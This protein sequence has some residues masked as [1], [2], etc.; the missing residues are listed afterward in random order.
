[1]DEFAAERVLLAADL[2]PRGRVASY[3]DLGRLAGVGPRQVGAIMAERGSEVSWWRIVSASG[4]LPAP[5]AARAAEH[6]D[7]EGITHV[8]GRVQMRRHRVDAAELSASYWSADDP[9]R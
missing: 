8:D 2:V 3:G 4:V 9:R 6:W 1:M 5:L 7:A